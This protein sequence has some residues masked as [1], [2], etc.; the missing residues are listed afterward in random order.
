M[1][2]A[3]VIA[4]IG[5]VIER[6]LNTSFPFVQLILAAIGLGSMI[7]YAKLRQRIIKKREFK[8]QVS[9]TAYLFPNLREWLGGH[10]G[11]AG[12]AGSSK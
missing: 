11:A 5:T 12:H 1:F 8:H 3:G 9:L 7:S 2:A 4:L 10:H 6:P